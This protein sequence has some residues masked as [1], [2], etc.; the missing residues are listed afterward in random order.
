MANKRQE[1]EGH[2]HHEEGEAHEEEEEAHEEEHG[3]I[4]YAVKHL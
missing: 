4:R 2:H 3:C 1:F